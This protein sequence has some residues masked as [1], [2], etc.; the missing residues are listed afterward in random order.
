MDVLW[1]RGPLSSEE[2]RLA[3]EKTH[4][5][6][7]S[8][9]R[10]I[11]KRLEDKGLRSPSRGRPNEDFYSGLEPRSNVA[12]RAVRRIIDHLYSG[13]VEELLDGMV[14]NEVV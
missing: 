9:T 5:M 12:A 1:N 8:T 2:V 10:T 13:S 6:K 3:L 11:L 14:N 4:F 7:E